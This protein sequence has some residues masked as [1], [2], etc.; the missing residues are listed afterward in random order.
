MGFQSKT[1]TRHREGDY[2]IIK[3]PVHL[4]DIKIVNIYA[5]SIGALRFIKKILKDVRGKIVTQ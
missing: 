2:V 3:W 4:K 1:A 5:P